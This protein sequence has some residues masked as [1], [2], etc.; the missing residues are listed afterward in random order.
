MEHT[1][2]FKRLYNKCYEL[3]S[4]RDDSNIVAFENLL[5]VD[6]SKVIDVSGENE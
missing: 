3:L 1:D 4:K 5:G 6:V 2:V